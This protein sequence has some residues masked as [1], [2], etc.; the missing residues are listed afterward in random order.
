MW[1]KDKSE[2]LLNS[3]CQTLKDTD[4]LTD[5]KGGKKRGAHEKLQTA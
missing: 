5:V 4:C 1:A 3:F 2:A